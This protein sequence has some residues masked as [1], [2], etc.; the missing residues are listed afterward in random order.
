[1][2]S[3]GEAQRADQ[4]QC[5]EIALEQTPDAAFISNLGN[6]SYVLSGVNDRDLN[7]YLW[8]SMGVTTPVGLGLAMATERPVTVFDGDGSMLMSLGA[9]ATVSN[10]NPSNLTIVIWDNMQYGTTGGQS[11]LS[12]TTDFA[13]VAKD[14]GITSFDT[15]SEEE[16]LECYTKAVE[17]DGSAVVVCHVDPV[18]PKSR[19]PFDFAHIKRRFRT[20]LSE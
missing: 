11:T 10:C 14:V 18:E 2:N 17:Y 7:F 4:I 1:M 5:T 3:E 20:A 15:A 12:A 13:A 16:F 6:A 8:G 19:P 9:L